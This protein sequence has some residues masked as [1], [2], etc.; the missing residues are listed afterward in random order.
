M[1]AGRLGRSGCLRSLHRGAGL[2]QCGGS[3]HRNAPCP[4]VKPVD[5]IGGHLGHGV[6][7]VVHE[8]VAAA[9]ADDHHGVGQPAGDAYGRHRDGRMPAAEILVEN[10]LVQR[11]TQVLQASGA[12]ASR[13]IIDGAADAVRAGAGEGSVALVGDQALV[14]LPRIQEPAARIVGK[15]HGLRGGVAAG[16]GDGRHRLRGAGVQIADA[17]PDL[18]T[19]PALVA[20]RVV[21]DRQRANVLRG[22]GCALQGVGSG[23]CFVGPER[24]RQQRRPLRHRSAVCA[25][26]QEWEK[27]ENHHQPTRSARH[28]PP[29]SRDRHP[30]PTL[31][32]GYP[33]GVNA[34]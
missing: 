20:L 34:P 19:A 10:G 17:C 11:G 7:R 26:D 5:G 31:A 14:V 2:R 1:C 25:P 8:I 21:G 15:D 27:S 16:V 6:V 3:G 22:S 18:G 33:A 23:A 29:A 30:S 4:A 32:R 13:R 9:L 12:A 28:G 24:P